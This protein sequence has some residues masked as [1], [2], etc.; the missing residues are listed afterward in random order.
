MNTSL[1]IYAVKVMGP[2]KL[3]HEDVQVT[4]DGIPII[5]HEFLMSE[6]GID[7]PLHSLSLEQVTHGRSSS[8]TCVTA[9]M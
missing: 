4:K 3:T 6:I 5:Y 8:V 9:D 7:A 2:F 1:V